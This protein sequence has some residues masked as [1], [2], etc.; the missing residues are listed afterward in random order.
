M[1]LTISAQTQPATQGIIL[2]ILFTD[3]DSY[4]TIT[5][6]VT[7]GHY[8]DAVVMDETGIIWD[9]HPADPASFSVTDY[10]APFN[11]EYTYTI[12]RYTAADLENP[13]GSAAD[14]TTGSPV[15]PSGVGMISSLPPNTYSETGTAYTENVTGTITDFQSVSRS[16]TILGN[17]RVLGRKNPVIVTDKFS[18]VTGSIALINI[19][20]ITT[21]I[22]GQSRTATYDV[23]DQDER[24]G[25]PVIFEDG[26][27]LLFRSYWRD[28]GIDDFYFKPTSLEIAR[29]WRTVGNYGAMNRMPRVYTVGFEEVDPFVQTVPADFAPTWAEVAASNTDWAEVASTHADWASVL[30]SPGL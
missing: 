13:V 5:R 7:S 19:S 21:G 12:Y 4:F 20:S 26:R 30:A 8:P 11:E 22:G 24:L 9:L 10:L 3:T 17:H 6:S 23:I 16:A 28:T 1:A 27:T 14:T 2:D 15:I 18:G 29:P 25:W